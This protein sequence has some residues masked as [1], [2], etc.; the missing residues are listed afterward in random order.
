MRQGRMLTLKRTTLFVQTCVTLAALACLARADSP[1]HPFSYAETSPD[2]KYLFVML[3]PVS[4]EDDGAFA[5]PEEMPKAKQVRAK[6]GASG[7]YL[8]DGSTTPLWTVDWYAPRVYVLSDGT[9]VV[10]MGQAVDDIDD[11]V[12]T[13]FAK[14]KVLRTYKLGDLVSTTSSI[15]GSSAFFYWEKGISLDDSSK[16]FT[17]TTYADDKLVFDVTTGEKVL[18]RK[19]SWTV[20]LCIS[21]FLLILVKAVRMVKRRRAG[22]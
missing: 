19:I 1:V 11:E 16:R 4:L 5:R 7:M 20:G 12:F 3:A 21:V 13:F 22:R 14:D 2:G 8:N 10:R 9:H 15:P 18:S 17:V 6:Y